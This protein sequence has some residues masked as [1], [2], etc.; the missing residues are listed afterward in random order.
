MTK[1]DDI[2][3][4]LPDTFVKYVDMSAGPDGCWPWTGLRDPRGYGRATVKGKSY[5][6]GRAS[7]VMLEAKLGHPLG[8]LLAC[9]TCDNPP[10][11]NP[12][13]LYAGTPT[14]NARDA[15]DRGRMAVGPRHWRHTAAN[16]G[17]LVGSRH[18]RAKLV[19]ADIVAIRNRVAAGERRSDVAKD[20]GITVDNVHR[21][22][23]R[24]SWRHV[25]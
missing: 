19:E 5:R 12:D 18:P 16:V 2:M 14:D 23:L 24:Y 10:C 15:L 25:A 9:H 11:V 8:D 20:F 1:A 13:H 3:A 22:V 21:I 7:R 17:Q 6:T 4:R